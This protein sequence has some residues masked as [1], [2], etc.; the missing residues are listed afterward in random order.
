VHH[1]AGPGLLFEISSGAQ[2]FGNVVWENAWSSHGWGSAGI[3][4]SSSANAEVFD[5]TLAWNAGGI[6]V[7]A[8]NRRDAAAA[9]AGNFVHDNTIVSTS[10]MLGLAWLTDDGSAMLD[11]ASGNH[12]ANNSY[13]FPDTEG[14][15]P[16][17]A[18]GTNRLR[19]EDFNATPGETNGR[20]LSSSE[21][22]AA[23]Q[24]AGLPTSRSS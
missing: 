22:D 12:G 2:I 11:P 17:F 15:A 8:Q 1:N 16:R 14:A 20:Y 9:I 3:G 6:E 4:I 13:W 7:L 21:R 23:L 19:L 24:A 18:W 5:N 10:G